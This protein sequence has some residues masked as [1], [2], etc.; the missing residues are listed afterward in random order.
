VVRHGDQDI[1]SGHAAAGAAGVA[2]V[3]GDDSRNYCVGV[4]RV[5]GDDD[6][7]YVAVS[8]DG[9]AVGQDDCRGKVLFVECA[10]QYCDWHVW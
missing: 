2:P 9:G 1:D 6:V 5:G 3:A 10:V 4:R 8:A 7:G